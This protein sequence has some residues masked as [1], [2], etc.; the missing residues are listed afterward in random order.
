[1]VLAAADRKTVAAGGQTWEQA[2]A[3]RRENR[4]DDHGILYLGPS[5]I[6]LII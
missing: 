6:N 5:A 4:A 1:M 3:V 2:P